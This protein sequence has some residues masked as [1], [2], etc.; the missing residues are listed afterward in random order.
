MALRARKRP[1]VTGAE[2]LP[3]NEGEALEDIETQGWARVHGEL[4]RVRSP[5]PLPRGARV[6]VTAQHGLT[7]DVEPINSAS[8]EKDHV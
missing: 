2:E 6:R 4:W 5:L 7:L 1:V 3:G 8:K